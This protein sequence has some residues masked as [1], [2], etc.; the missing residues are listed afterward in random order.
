M[1]Q[2]LKKRTTMSERDKEL[3]K[4]VLEFYGATDK[5]LKLAYPVDYNDDSM[6]NEFLK[7]EVRKHGYL[8]NDYGD[9]EL[10][11]LEDEIA[12]YESCKLIN[13]LVDY[14]GFLM[15]ETRNQTGE[16]K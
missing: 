2:Q 9:L 7:N 12:N 10:C 5:L 13:M 8:C 3:E 14:R 4:A 16:K 6:A 11:D 1:E 15:T